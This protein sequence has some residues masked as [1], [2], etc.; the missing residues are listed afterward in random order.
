MVNKISCLQLLRTRSGAAYAVLLAACL[1]FV[2]GV[3][4]NAGEIRVVTEEFPP[5]NL[6]E[7]G[8][9]TGFSTEV[10]EAVLKEIGVQAGIQSMPWARAYDIARNTENVLIYSIARTPEREKLFKWVGAVAPSD[11]S[12]FAAREGGIRIERLDD[13][14]K[15]QV[16]TVNEDAGEQFLVSR[17]FVIGKNLQSS[18]K[19]EFNYDKL[20][21]GRVDLWVA[22]DLV[23]RYLARRAGDNPDQVLARVLY[24]PE[25]SGSDGLYMAFGPKTSDTVVERFRKG[26]DAIKKS[27]KYEALKRKWL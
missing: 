15:Y 17:G 10:V 14:K 23:A 4:A 12:L 25:L 1:L 13:A 26:L 8:K 21:R 16:A 18:N 9:V 22:N 2:G 20:K 5:Y 24:L 11:W 7:K 3:S 27:G 6:T 19:Y